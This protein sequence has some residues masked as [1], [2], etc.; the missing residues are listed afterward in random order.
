MDERSVPDDTYEEAARHFTEKELIDLTMAVGFI[1]VANRL[2]IAFE[3]PVE[4]YN[5]GQVVDKL[6]QTA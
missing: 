5:V 4:D 6:A 3:T 1:N 2:N